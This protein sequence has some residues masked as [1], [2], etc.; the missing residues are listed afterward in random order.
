MDEQKK[1]AIKKAIAET[2][3]FFDIF[4]YPLNAWELWQYN[5]ISCSYQDFILILSELSWPNKNG[6]YFLPGREELL[7]ERAKRYNYTDTK[8][9]IAKRMASIFRFLPWVDMVAVSNIIGSHNLRAE[10]DID[11]FIISTKYRIWLCRFFC[12]GL[13]ALLNKRPRPK[14]KKNKICLSFYIDQSHLQLKD[15][16]LHANDIY[17]NYWVLGLVP[18]FVRADTYFNFLAANLWLKEY[19]PNY[20][21]NKMS[22]RRYFATKR[23]IKYNPVFGYLEKLARRFQLAIMPEKLKSLANQSSAVIISDGILKL[24]L[25][26]KRNDIYATFLDKMKQYG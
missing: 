20:E 14:N 18:L 22:S 5:K 21:G 2:I 15:F 25:E 13:M 4:K 23:E 16:R 17:F 3:V 24:F 9:K 1:Q 26:D 6:F 7:A 19:F 10:S 11:I 8:M 12:T